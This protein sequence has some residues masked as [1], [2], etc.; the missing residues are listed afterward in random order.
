M[1][2]AGAADE[3]REFAGMVSE[4]YERMGRALI[5]RDARIAALAAELTDTKRQLELTERSYNSD[6]RNALAKHDELEA[7]NRVLRAKEA[8]LDDALMSAVELHCGNRSEAAIDQYEKA[9]KALT[10][11]GWKSAAR[12]RLAAEHGL[13]LPE[14]ER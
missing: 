11:S 2:A 4:S 3:W 7:E 14:V 12:Q 10:D 5:E 8:L 9:L 1:P 13:P 6:M